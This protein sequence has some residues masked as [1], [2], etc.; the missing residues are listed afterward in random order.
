MNVKVH[1]KL[2]NSV[3]SLSLGDNPEKRK[4][5]LLKMG[6]IIYVLVLKCPLSS[7]WANGKR[8]LPGTGSLVN[9]MLNQVLHTKY[10]NQATLIKL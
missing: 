1:I 8:G 9:L 6:S 2:F 7:F 10:I 3:I 5:I 4:I